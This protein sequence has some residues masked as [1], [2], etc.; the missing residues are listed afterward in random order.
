M[1]KRE[2][3]LAALSAF[4]RQRPGLEFGNYGD[5]KAYRSESRSITRDLHIAERLLAQ[6]AWRTSIDEQALRDA[7]RAYSGRLT[8]EDRPDGAIAIDYCTGQCFPTEY[9]KAVCAVLAS[10]LWAYARDNAPIGAGFH[11]PHSNLQNLGDYLRSN[12]R[13]EFGASIANRFFN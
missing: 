10:A 4:A 6:V 3:I 12:F 5:V 13:R 2:Q 8:I 7:F 11:E 9:R 1:N